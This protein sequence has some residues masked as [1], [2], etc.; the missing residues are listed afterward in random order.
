MCH[1]SEIGQNGLILEKI[2]QM[3][4]TIFTGKLSDKQK[5]VPLFVEIEVILLLEK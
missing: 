3:K 5:M 1:D 2:K 4:V